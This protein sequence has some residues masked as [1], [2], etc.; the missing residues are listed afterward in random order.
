MTCDH[1]S[2]PI[3]VQIQLQ[4]KAIEQRLDKGDQRFAQLGEKLDKLLYAF[5]AA[6]GIVS[7]IKWLAAIAAGVGALWAAFGVR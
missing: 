2:C 7:G 5:N 1:E 3:Q 6:N 4:L